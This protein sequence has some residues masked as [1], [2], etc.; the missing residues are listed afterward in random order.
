MTVANEGKLRS[1]VR[2]WL[3]DNWDDRLTVAEWWRRLAD[4]GWGFPTWPR[5]WFGQDLSQE[6]AVVVREELAQARVLGPPA[7]G[8]PAMAAP[9]ILRFGTEA[10]KRRW[11]PAIAYGDEHW[12]QFFSEPGAGSDLASVQTRAV[13]DGDDWIVNGQKVWNSGTLVADRALLVARTNPD[14]PKHQGLTFFMIEVVQPGIEVRPIRQMNGYAE[15]N[16]SFFTDARVADAD[17]LGELG[18]GWT[19]ALAV[20]NHE[21]STFAGGGS[22]RALPGAESGQRSGNLGRPVGEVLAA[23]PAGPLSANALPL[24]SIPAVLALARAHGRGSDPVIRQR[25]AAVYS[26]SEAL[27][28]T[29]LRGQ[30][31]A[32][33]GRGGG[34]ESS[35]AY[36]AGVKLIR[37]Y[38]DLVAEIAGAS[39]LVVDDTK[40]AETIT[41]APA[42]GI[43]GGTEQ[44][45]RTV[46]GERLLGLPKEPQSD[47]DVPFRFLE[48]G[49]RRGSP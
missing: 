42:H 22:G 7:G 11:L 29:G 45:Q 28:F 32:R 27:R 9:V 20:L 48:V 31:A 10:Q 33:A 34:A 16:E 18:G 30:E 26:L 37:L 5:E 8:G 39:A 43:Q 23:A 40:V 13:R 38:R 44:I 12:A 41:T 14:L 17:R 6:A 36:L 19:V 2:S 24:G 46:I 49:T 47:R 21:R 4:S 25:I 1:E 15:F 35:V 3:G